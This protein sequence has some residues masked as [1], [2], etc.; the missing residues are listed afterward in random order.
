MSKKLYNVAIVGATGVVG[1]EFIKI[2]GEREF[3]VGQL[4][5]LASERSLG[6]FYPFKEKEI[7]VDVLEPGVFKGIDIALF[8]A[9]AAISKE[10]APIAVAEGAIVIDNTSHFR[11]EKDIPLVVPEVN[12][13]AIAEHSKRKIIANPNCSTIQMVVVLH[14]LRQKA[15][16]KRV[17]VSTYQ[18]VSGAGLKAMEELSLQTAALL[19]GAEL[20]KEKFPHQIA[21]NCLPHIDKFLDGGYTKEEL[22]MMAETSKIMGENI[23][24]TATCVRVPVFY[25]HSEAVNIEF[26]EEVTVA[27]AKKLLQEAE[28]IE[29]ID[30]PVNNEYPLA[31]DCSGKDPVFVGRIRKDPTV[32]HGLNLW[33]VADNVRK[34]AALNAIQIAEVLQSSLRGGL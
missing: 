31:I 13:Q 29:L 2:L 5:L 1:Q 26:E 7:P 33:I 19:S 34:G 11:M 20:K 15:K 4:K 12:P 10:F 22:K 32:P 14:A 16:I 18:S 27:D 8:S 6:R 23:P 25:G 3:P 9:G 24:V 30:D 28:G 17:V 21:Y